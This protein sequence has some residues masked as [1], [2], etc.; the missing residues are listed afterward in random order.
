VPLGTTALV[1]TPTIP[2]PPP[3]PAIRPL[4]PGGAPGR[5][6]QVEKER[7]EEAA[8]E[9]SQAFSRY[10]PEDGGPPAYLLGLILIAALAGVSMRGSGGGRQRVRPAPARSAARDIH[11]KGQPPW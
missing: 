5:V 4:P 6:Y 7:E 1:N 9:Q 10:E 8:P 2:P 11:R 3:P